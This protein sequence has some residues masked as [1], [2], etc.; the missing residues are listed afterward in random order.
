[1]PLASHPQFLMA[2]ICLGM[3]GCETLP[4]WGLARITDIPLASAHSDLSFTVTSISSER[5]SCAGQSVCP[6][7]TESIPEVR[8][9][10][11]VERIATALQM[12]AQAMHSDLAQRGAGHRFDVYVVEGDER[13]SAS[14][15]NGRISLNAALAAGQP[16][17]AWVAF[18]IAREM[19]H[20][21]ARHHEENSGAS[22]TTSIILNIL[23]PVTGVLKSIMS[24]A[25]SILAARSKRDIQ[26]REA[27]A[28]AF[29]LLEAAGFPLRDVAH[30]LRLAPAPSDTGT[31]SA[32]FRKSATDL[33]AEVR[34]ADLIEEER[35]K[36]IRST[37]FA[38]K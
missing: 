28:I 37:R 17:D 32:N 16:D 2:A 4:N 26:A 21:I 23:L 13:S 10:R 9:V 3:A 1:M 24:T 35:A 34:K 19:G 30:G 12:G 11:Q 8:F 20:V 38:G 29:D 27:D 15:A 31:W 5:I 36:Q 14:S 25:G 6:N 33:L 7:E 18:I 22:I